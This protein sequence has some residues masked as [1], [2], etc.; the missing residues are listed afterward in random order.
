MDLDQGLGAPRTAAAMPPEVAAGGGIVWDRSHVLVVHRPRYDDW[1]LPKGKLDAVDAGDVEACA[2]REVLEETG[3]T[4]E[5]GAPAGRTRYPVIGRGGEAA[6]K[7]VDYWH[8]RRTGGNF[9]PNRE[10][11]AVRWLAVTEAQALLTFG[12]DRL[13]LEGVTPGA[14]SARGVLG[15]Y[16]TAV[17]ARDLDGLEAVLADDFVAVGPGGERVGRDDFLAA[18]VATFAGAG[19]VAPLLGP[20]DE[21][22]SNVRDA[23]I[24][25]LH[26]RR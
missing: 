3:V 12:R 6:T 8:M 11:D 13:L 7:V 5:V 4:V 17:R 19:P 21:G 15:R 18:A 23:R 26:V 10:V 16:E 25:E 1:T 22:R 9:T 2:V 24:T 20:P 14:T